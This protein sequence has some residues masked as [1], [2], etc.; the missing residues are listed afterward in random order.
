M[1][2]YIRIYRKI[3]E[4]PIFNDM[5]LFRLWMICLTE[6][7][8]KERDQIIGRQTVHLMPGEFVTGRFDLQEMYNHGL[9]RDQQKS[10]KTVSRWLDTLKTG[11]FLTI[12][13]TNKF[14]VVSILNWEKYQFN[15]HENDQQVTNKRPTSDQQVTTNNNVFNS[16]NDLNDIKKDI[17]DF[18]NSLE[19][20]QHREF[21]Q[22]MKSHINARLQKYSQDELTQAIS[23]YNEI[24]KSPDYWYTHKFTLEKFMDPKNLSAFLTENNPYQNY[25]IKKNQGK[26]NVIDEVQQYYLRKKE[27]EERE[28]IGGH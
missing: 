23:N 14:S 9:K 18:W 21:T 17:Y 2:G 20:I 7:T 27:E 10:P 1:Q 13:T 6:A 8:H 12:K 5:E 24:I 25:A 26:P 19:I 15:D 16:S 28:A 4:N 3:R 22:K 11:E